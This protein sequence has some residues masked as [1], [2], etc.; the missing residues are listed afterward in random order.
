M[1]IDVKNIENYESMTAEEKVAALEA[2]DT[3]LSGFVP[4]S[5]FDKTASDL[6]A[7]KKQL[8]E[9]MTEDE[10]QKAREAE[11]KAAAD[12]RNA[13]LE[14]RVKELETEKAIS[15]YVNSYLAMGYDEKMAKSSAEALAKGDTE[16]VFKNQKAFAENREKA[17][18]AE[19]LKETP[20]PAG[21]SPSK[22][23][24]LEDFRKM[25]PQERH[26]FSVKNPEEYKNLYGGNE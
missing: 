6:A 12:A 4:K 19:L 8:R 7:A 15:G 1:K 10:A 22:G 21:G 13:E 25:S 17:L 9:K 24:T 11:E 26:D 16:T 18:K 5:T 20:P 3:D 14:A 2:Y 23:M